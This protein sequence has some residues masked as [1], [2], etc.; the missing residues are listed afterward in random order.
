M[1]EDAPLP[2]ADRA[3][4]TFGTPETFTKTAD[5][6]SIRLVRFFV[7]SANR[8]A[9]VT[10]KTERASVDAKPNEA[11]RGLDS[12]PQSSLRDL[13]TVQRLKN[14]T[15]FNIEHHSTSNERTPSQH[16]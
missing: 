16:R 11:E 14:V 13:V 2:F 9:F 12:P 3:E 15:L 7:R 1:N 10:N 5:F 6:Q 8:C 4:R